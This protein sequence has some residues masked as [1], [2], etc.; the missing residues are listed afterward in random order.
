MKETTNVQQAQSA[1]QST[2]WD[3]LVAAVIAV[4]IGALLAVLVCVPYDQLFGLPTAL[5]A[6]LKY[7]ASVAVFATGLSSGRLT[8]RPFVYQ[9][10]H[11]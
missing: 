5:C 1:G 2:V 4:A 3:A 6:G 11:T 7:T 8:E 10:G 9:V